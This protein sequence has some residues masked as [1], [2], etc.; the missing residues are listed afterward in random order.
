[1][2]AIP[3]RLR[4]V[5]RHWLFMAGAGLLLF[6]LLSSPGSRAQEETP[7]ADS[8]SS[9][10]KIEAG[11]PPVIHIDS[12]ELGGGTLRCDVTEIVRQQCER[13]AH[14]EIEVSKS[15]CPTRRLPG[16]VQ[17]LKVGYTCRV[18]EVPRP[19]TAEEPDRLRLLCV[20]IHGRPD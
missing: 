14:C 11:N 18:G 10:A 9:A 13:R 3:Q 8:A 19:V 17:P 7:G 20:P 15:L 2:N 5:P 16:L 1:M 6:A 12:A 4:P